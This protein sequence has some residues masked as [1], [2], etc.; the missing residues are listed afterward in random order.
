MAYIL[1]EDGVVHDPQTALPMLV[2]ETPAWYAWLAHESRFTFASQQ[3]AFLARKE[4]PANGRG[5]QYWRAYR[6][7]RGK[8]YRVY[9]GKSE[10]VTVARLHA[11]AQELAR[12]VEH[13]NC[14]NGTSRRRAG[15]QSRQTDQPIL[16]AAQ[17]NIPVQITSLLLHTKMQIPP[18][19]QSLVARPRLIQLLNHGATKRLIL[20]SAAAGSGKTTVLSEWAHHSSSLVAWL[21]LDPDDNDHVRFWSYLITALKQATID[22]VMP[23]LQTLRSFAPPTHRDALIELL[24]GLNGE[25]RDIVIILDDYHLIDTPAIHDSLCFFLEHL[26]A[27]VHLVLA[28]RA[29]PPIPLGQWRARDWLFELHATDLRFTLDEAATFFQQTEHLS[30]SEPDLTTV[31]ERTEGWVAGLRLAALAAHG[32]QDVSHIVASFHGNH[33]LIMNYLLDDILAH[34]P[35]AVRRFVLATSVLDRLTA[36]LCDWLTDEGNGQAML[37]HL[38]H[39]HLFLTALDGDGAWYRYHHLFTE[40]L[41]SR[42]RQEQ[43][44]RFRTLHRQASVWYERQALRHEAVQH[45]LVAEDFERAADLMDSLVDG[46]VQQNEFAG[47]QN[48]LDLLPAPVLAQRPRLFLACIQVCIAG[49]QLARAEHYIQDLE[50]WGCQEHESSAALRGKLAALQA[51]LLSVRGQAQ[52]ALVVAHQAQALLPENDQVWRL[53]VASTMGGAYL[54]AGQYREA[55]QVFRDVFTSCLRQQDIHRAIATL[56]P[57]GQAQLL[58]GRLDL[59]NVTYLQGL[60]LASQH[61]LS[62]S[63]V[64]GH[65]HAGRGNLLY[66]WNDLAGAEEHL[67]AGIEL[68]QRGDHRI[69]TLECT[70][71]LADVRQAQGKMP[72]A[73]ALLQQA[74]DLAEQTGDLFYVDFVRRRPVTLWL[75]HHDVEAASRCASASGLYQFGEARDVTELPS[76][77]FLLI[78]LLTLAQLYI[79][80]RDLP[81][82]ERLLSQIEVLLAGGQ[83]TRR[84]IQWRVLQALALHAER[85]FA[86]AE[87]ALACALELAEPMRYIR[88]FVDLG[89]ALIPLCTTLLRSRPL[90]RYSHGY[91]RQLLA[92]LGAPA[93]T[94]ETPARDLLTGRELT[95]LRC[96]VEGNSDREIARC[97]VMTENT[98][99]THTRRI[100]RKLDV[101]SRTQA[102]AF[103][104]QHGWF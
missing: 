80:Q 13:G 25:A 12:R 37:A 36:P 81:R 44:A 97:L 47:L 102:V 88:T 22:S 19:P 104:R 4:R 24:N 93:R 46:M 38:E 27:H 85:R 29:D 84:R 6:K 3:G 69:Q 54:H 66:E 96:L 45:A 55:E 71:T 92:T 1:Q 33:H 31:V 35:E 43:P 42:L 67:L 58:S 64:A 20:I 34:Q 61:G 74:H 91:L 89:D 8:L 73:L 30:L 75:A 5:D 65:L 21:T 39:A 14:A 10:H 94:N 52:E 70:L 41:R 9:V 48:W 40:A 28:T 83:H 87:A 77:F 17:Q 101:H 78:E 18:F 7:S 95:V 32:N 16:S 15:A 26:P 23:A 50:H 49:G 90:A 68:A 103:A 99:K 57:L 82:A 51:Q 100:Y 60:H 86:E 59:V 56:H 79:A 62:Q 72:E 53:H 76:T 63:A 11:V 98:V 2:A